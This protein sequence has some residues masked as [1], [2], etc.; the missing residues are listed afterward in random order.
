MRR[1][2]IALQQGADRLLDAR[3]GISQVDSM[4]PVALASSRDSPLLPP[5]PRREAGA[6]CRTGRRRF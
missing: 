3:R 1:L 4:C 5:R 6:T 2:D